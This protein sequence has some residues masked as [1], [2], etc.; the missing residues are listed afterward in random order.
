MASGATNANNGSNFIIKS[1]W[2][3]I[4]RKSCDVNAFKPV[5][6]YNVRNLRFKKHYAFLE[7]FVCCGGLAELF[8]EIEPIVHA[9]N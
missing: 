1:E 8:I 2:L 4:F 5:D 9:K 7:M 3:L 6:R